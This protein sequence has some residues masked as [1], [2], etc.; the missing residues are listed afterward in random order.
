MPRTRPSIRAAARSAARILTLGAIAALV[1]QP[2]HAV[3]GPETGTG[4]PTVSAT[5]SPMTVAPNSSGNG[6]IFHLDN[7]NNPTTTYDLGCSFVAP[8]TS[9][10]VQSSITIA[11]GSAADVTITYAVGSSP[12]NGYVTLS[13]ANQGASPAPSLPN[14]PPPAEYTNCY[15]NLQ[16]TTPH[17][18]L[19]PTS[20][21]FS[22]SQGGADPAPQSV[23]VTNSGGGT[24]DWTASPGA[25][26][27]SVSPGSGTG[28]G[29]V[30]VT[31][32]TGTLATGTYTGSVSV[33]DANADNSP[34]SVAVTFTVNPSGT[35]PPSVT[36][37]SGS[38]TVNANTSGNGAFFTVS[39]PNGS[40]LTYTLAC[41]FT[42]Q[43]TYCSVDPSVTV[44]A[45]GASSVTVRFSAASAGYGTITLTATGTG[46]SDS[47]SYNVTVGNPTAP[48]GPIEV[49]A[50]INPGS[51]MPRSSCVTVGAGPAGASQ[52]GELLVAQG[53]PAY[54][55][56]NRDRALTLLYTSGTAKPYPIVLANVALDL[57]I[58]VPDSLKATLV[59]D[60]VTRAVRW[61]NDLRIAPG[62]NA[63]RI[64][65]GFDAAAA[66]VTTGLH[67]FTLTVADVYSDTICATCETAASGDLIVVNR[68]A[69]PY[70]AG[71]GI[72]GVEELYP[73]QRSGTA[74]LLVDGDG[75]TAVYDAIGGSAYLAP[76][77][78]HRDT[79]FYETAVDPSGSSTTHYR[80]RLL[81]GTQLYFN[82]AGQETWVQ[83]RVS[84]KV[85]Y[86]YTGGAGS[87]VSQ[88][89]IAPWDQS[90]VYTF[91]YGSPNA[92]LSAV[93]DP[94]SRAMNIT[95]NGSG[96]LTDFYLPDRPDSAIVLAYAAHLLTRWTSRLG[97]ATKY[98]Y[99][100]ETALLAADTLPT[101][102]AGTPVT[103]FTPLQTLG[104]A[105]TA[106]GLNDTYAAASADFEV[107]GPRTHTIQ[108]T[109]FYLDRFGAPTRIIDAV[110]N[111]T[112]LTYDSNFP[113]LPKEVD[114]PNGRQTTTAYDVVGRVRNAADLTSSAGADSTV[115]LYST[116]APDKPWKVIAP[117]SG[118]TRDTT[119]FN[120]SSTDGTLDNV[121]DPR[122][123][124]TSFTYNSRGQVASVTEQSVPVYGDT[125]QD[126]STILAN[127]DSNAGNLLSSTTP[128]G[129]TTS[130]AYDA[131]GQV[132]RVTNPVGDS[133]TYVHDALGNLTEVDHYDGVYRRASHFTYDAD[134]DRTTAVDPR[135]TFSRS[136]HYNALGEDTA[137]IDGMGATEFHAYDLAGNLT[138]R[139]NRDSSTVAIQYDGVNRPKQ[140]VLSSTYQ[141]GVLGVVGTTINLQYDAAGNVTM[142]DEDS[143]QVTRVFNKEGTLASSTQLH[144]WSGT[145]R[146]YSSA[147]QWAGRHTLSTPKGT[148]TYTLGPGGLVS[149]IQTPAGEMISFHYDALGRRDT[150][151]LPNTTKTSYG[152]TKDGQIAR[153]ISVNATSG[154]TAVDL[155]FAYDAA[156]R[157]DSVVNRGNETNNATWVDRWAY[158][159]SGRIRYTS[160]SHPGGTSSTDSMVYDEAGNRVKEY[161]C[162]RGSLCADSVL[163]Q[164]DG[165]SNEVT[166]RTRYYSGV[167]GPES[168]DFSYD[169]NG[170][171]T[172]E[173]GTYAGTAYT[174][175]RYYSAAGQLSGTHPD[176][177]FFRYDGLGRRI[178]GAYAH[179]GAETFYDGQ[180]VIEHSTV[181]FVDGPGLDDPLMMYG[182]A[183]CPLGSLND[184]R[185]YFI[186]HRERLFS[187]QGPQGE[188]CITDTN[189][190]E[191]PAWSTWGSQ[192]GAIRESYSFAPARNG[193]SNQ[194]TGAFFRN[195]YY[196]ARLGRF[197][198]E[199]PIGL[200][201][202]LNLYSYNGDN[203]ASYTDPF[204]LCP[205]CFE[206]AAGAVVGVAE[207]YLITKALGGDYTLSQGITDAAL[208]AV[209]GGLVEGLRN[210]NRIRQYGAFANEIP[211][212][213]NARLQGAI[214]QLFRAGDKLPG[215]TAGAIREELRTG[216]LVGG[217]SHL[218]KGQQRARQL[219]RILQQEELSAAD[220]TT[221]QRVLTDLQNALR[222]H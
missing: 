144:K 151:W 140:R 66:G 119:T 55:T 57:G 3:G 202:G 107:R 152:Y 99:T 74:V 11:A 181:E 187:F 20:L 92:K 104:L 128:E 40:P 21:S 72:A 117:R 45:N 162:V 205:I 39:N 22:A 18:V 109:K 141:N 65:V 171:E 101:V 172:L 17:I 62:G 16:T 69:G 98:S 36:P 50:A 34:Q 24:L 114:W 58:R 169:A 85:Q 76:V 63:R 211:A 89:R 199:D 183:A 123:H 194:E 148:Y 196:D 7:K 220:R 203:P 96:D 191:L 23:S 5:N 138:L 10:S 79:I 207:G 41:G 38:L 81:D 52:C 158:D 213:A 71:W 216:E 51:L 82:T 192:S 155:S 9:C 113:L 75:S 195:R 44:G 184:K 136:W 97:H 93:T 190:N 124:E 166:R 204:G 46:G 198:Q 100:G 159:G 26:W 210:A 61:F 30:S 142:L 8:V 179:S 112:V 164:L 47:G 80:R 153:V 200:A 6:A 19:S 48:E 13:V 186:T 1:G 147:Y 180:N 53:M 218:L 32:H 176:T 68:S 137:M 131:N 206:I 157:P 177:A 221:A 130:Y 133:L 91:A 25:S 77:G 175:H 170:N 43:V 201:G 42:G 37:D 189:G 103:T 139:R 217:R 88:I 4:L 125:V 118:A 31:A 83:D 197:T 29:S 106:T 214:E 59:V 73:N 108:I 120:Y 146:T 208:G 219:Q 54:R 28:N 156:G 95:V 87:G 49:N 149:Q 126:L 222:G 167:S 94:A 12:S 84:N 127:D 122:G 121:I 111:T 185:A 178:R 70:G 134:G 110:G 150:V 27:L 2:A 90:R 132:R 174:W 102:S 86:S 161:L 115:Y 145:Q 173:Q 56:M 33:S 182:N 60:G 215:G 105:T 143:S 135:M 35:L 193:D 64:A 129:H 15:V 209:G 14:S 116:A 78:A 165:L 154:D 160:Q 188:N 67:T 212:A 168:V 163:F